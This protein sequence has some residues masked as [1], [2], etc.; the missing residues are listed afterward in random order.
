LI[1]QKL[2]LAALFARQEAR[3]YAHQMLAIF[4]QSKDSF[5]NSIELSVSAVTTRIDRPGYPATSRARRSCDSLKGSMHYRR[6]GREVY[7]GAI[8][9]LPQDLKPFPQTETARQPLSQRAIIF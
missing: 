3:F 6:S 2:R 9:A 1:Q 7:V 8:P 5:T 4:L